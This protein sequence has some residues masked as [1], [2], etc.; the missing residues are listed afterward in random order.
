MAIYSSL[1]SRVLCCAPLCLF[2]SPICAYYFR[3][4]LDSSYRASR[5]SLTFVFR[6]VSNALTLSMFKLYVPKIEKEVIE[7]LDA[8]FPEETGEIDF[9]A[10]INELTVLTSTS[11]LHLL[12]LLIRR[13]RRAWSLIPSSSRYSLLECW[14]ISFCSCLL[15]SVDS[16]LL[17]S[18]CVLIF[19]SLSRCLQGPEIRAQVH[20]G[21]SALIG[22]LD[23]ALSAIGFFYP[24]LPL[25]TYIKRY[26]S[27]WFDTYI[28]FHSLTA[29]GDF[30]SQ[31]SFIDVCD[32]YIIDLL[33]SYHDGQQYALDRLL[34]DIFDVVMPL[35][36][37]SAPCSRPFSRRAVRTTSRATM[38]SKSSWSFSRPLSSLIF[39]SLY[40]FLSNCSLSLRLIAKHLFYGRITCS[41]F[42]ELLSCIW[43]TYRWCVVFRITV[44]MTARRSPMMRLSATSLPSWLLV[45]CTSLEFFCAPIHPILSLHCSSIFTLFERFSGHCWL[46]YYSS[47]LIKSPSVI[48]SQ[49]CSSRGFILVWSF[50]FLLLLTAVVI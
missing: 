10:A 29:N 14:F 9:S 41:I 5:S 48:L 36:V 49:L 12:P 15:E 28:S 8:R 23:H 1:P 16:M 20:T 24:S 18:A 43:C 44:M 19:L 6:F 31:Q 46:S 2:C 50:L 32:G 27:V 38:S 3:R 30:E 4:I 21:Y 25:P 7:F 34:C 17:P 33:F 45:R 11:Y 13:L 40:F 26:P 37:S 35:V 39:H 47:F 42:V 22:A